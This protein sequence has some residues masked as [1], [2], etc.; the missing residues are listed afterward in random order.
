MGVCKLIK[1]QRNDHDSH[2]DHH[3]EENRQSFLKTYL[4]SLPSRRF[5]IHTHTYLMGVMGVMGV[6]QNYQ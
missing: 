1:C 6:L 2:K 4:R 3:F 5:Y